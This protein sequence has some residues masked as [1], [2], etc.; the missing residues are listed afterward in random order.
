MRK[1][2]AG[3]SKS[4]GSVPALTATPRGPP[5][6][7]RRDAGSVGPAQATL[8]SRWI[9]LRSFYAWAA[10]EDEMAG[11]P[12]LGV[13]VDRAEPPPP[14]MP[15]DTELKLLFKACA[16]RGI[17]ERRDPRDDPPRTRYR[18]PGERT[19]RARAP[20]RRPAEPGHRHPS[21]QGPQE[22]ARHASIPR[23]VPP[24][25][26]VPSHA[27]T[28]SARGISL[29]VFI[30]RFGP[31]GRKGAASMLT[32]RCEQAGVAHVHWHQFRHRFVPMAR[33]RA[34]R[35]ATSRNSAA[36][37]TRALCALRVRTRHRT[38]F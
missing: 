9:A 18:R 38:R 30:T 37:P 34:V 20:R 22:P 8:R 23:R 16:G 19:L 36:G 27:G 17:W 29:P 11:N 1:C 21:G 4:L 7:L 24:A 15:D 2:C 6:L 35:K 33:A 10:D 12:M 14:A 32:R 3:F 26:S 25:R 28:A 5:D 31:I 13:K